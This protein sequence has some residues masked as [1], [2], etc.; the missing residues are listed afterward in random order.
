MAAL[1]RIHCWDAIT[2]G[3]I[4][5]KGAIP[6]LQRLEDALFQKTSKG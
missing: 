3:A 2:L 4:R 1:I 5:E 6:H